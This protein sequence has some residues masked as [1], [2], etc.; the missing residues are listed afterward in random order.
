MTL[1]QSLILGIIQGLTE[2]LPISSSAHLVLIPQL[3]GWQIPQSQVFP[4]DVLVQLGTLVA[5]II[6]FWKDLWNIIKGF[7]KALADRQPFGSDDARMG[8]FLILATIPAGLAGILIKDTVEA[9]F[10]SAT[11]TAIFLFVTALFLVLAELLGKRSRSLTDI[12]WLDALVIGLFQVI[13]LFPG[14]SRSGST[15]SAGMFRKFDRPSAAR[16]SF[17]MSV[18]VMLGA[19]LVSLNDAIDMPGFSEF[20]PIILVGFLAALLVGYLAI[21]WFLSFLGKRSLYVFAIYCV[22]LGSLV[23]ILGLSKNDVKA[24]TIQTPLAPPASVVN[25]GTPTIVP[26]F[27]ANLEE[28]PLTVAYT[29]SLSWLVPVMIVCTDSIPGLTTV[30][31]E[32]TVGTM[33]SSVEKIILQWGFPVIPVGAVFTLGSEELAIFVNSNNPLTSLSVPLINGIY[34]GQFHTWGAVFEQCPD[35]FSSA[36]SDS[37][38]A[39]Q[40]TLLSFSSNEEPQS[41]FL[42][43]FMKGLDKIT[44]PGMLV[45]DSSAMISAIEKDPAAIGFSGSHF[46][47]SQVKR[48]VVTAV[49]SPVELESPILAVTGVEPSPTMSLWLSCIQ[50]I[51]TPK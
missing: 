43:V 12:K 30:L 20:L 3:L 47:T 51:L 41:L 18:P 13:S 17:L 19:G 26:S 36:L 33:N 46:I 25:S 21:H 31:N 11:A 2:F 49:E 27:V 23:L 16:F 5:V 48:V 7:V 39:Q 4:F 40:I 15:I 32:K 42:N 45:P 8:W 44:S 14:I 24:E 35:C 9:A 34:T 50:K 22:I 37:F 38:Q 10:N 28:N 29:S 6:Y 1:I